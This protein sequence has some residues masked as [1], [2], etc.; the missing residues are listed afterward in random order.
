MLGYRFDEQRNPIFRYD[1]GPVHV[2]EMPIPILREGGADL[3]RRFMLIADAPGA[4]GDLY[5]QIAAG[6]K[7]EPVSDHAW[8]IDDRAT[9]T[10][11]PGPGAGKPML[12]LAADN[13]QVIVPV[14]FTDG[15]SRIEVNWSW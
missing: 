13:R 5:L 12:R 8:R 15:K 10:L 9:V 14:E 7:I 6:K 3:T 2:E 11:T 1:L 4:P